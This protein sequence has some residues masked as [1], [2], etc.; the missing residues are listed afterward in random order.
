M[1]LRNTYTAL[2]VR[3]A[4]DLGISEDELLKLLGEGPK[5]SEAMRQSVG[6]CSPAV[7]LRVIKQAKICP[8][9]D[10]VY[11]SNIALKRHQYREKRK[12]EGKK[13]RTQ[14]DPKNQQL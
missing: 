12:K 5:V 13:R 7:Q 14:V 9:C 2:V 4:R 3:R 11:F 1:R 10:G 6:I 8:D